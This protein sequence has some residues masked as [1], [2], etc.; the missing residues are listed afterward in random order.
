MKCYNPIIECDEYL[1]R[2]VK[3]LSIQCWDLLMKSREWSESGTRRGSQFV[4]CPVSFRFLIIGSGD[5]LSLRRR[6]GSSDC[7]VRLE[8]QSTESI[9]DFEGRIAA[10]YK[11]QV[12]H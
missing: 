3:Y 1:S 8:E 10:T 6:R 9:I 12:V 7:P 4:A 5:L 2:K 11:T